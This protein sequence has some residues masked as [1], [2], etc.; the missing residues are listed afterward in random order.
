[1]PT[2]VA[3]MVSVGA[4]LTGNRLGLVHSLPFIALTMILIS[5]PATF[6]LTRESRRS[7]PA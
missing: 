7:S 2:D 6:L 4:H 1:M 3:M 5:L